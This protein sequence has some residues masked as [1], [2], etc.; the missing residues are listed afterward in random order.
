MVILFPGDVLVELCRFLITGTRGI[1]PP[2]VVP[3]GSLLLFFDTLAKVVTDT[4]F[5]DI[6]SRQIVAFFYLTASAFFDDGK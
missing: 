2:V 4:I 6:I 3:V 5:L 1:F